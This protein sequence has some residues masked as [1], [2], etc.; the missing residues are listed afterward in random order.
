MRCDDEEKIYIIIYNIFY[1]LHWV[2]GF[3][4]EKIFFK[5]NTTVATGEEDNTENN[6]GE[7]VIE[8]KNEEGDTI[9]Y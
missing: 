4:G 5:N 2:F 3:F 1:V 6:T 9:F 8:P 7:D